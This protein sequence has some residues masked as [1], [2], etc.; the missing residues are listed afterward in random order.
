MFAE[1][2]YIYMAREKFRISQWLR[3]DLSQ[4]HGQLLHAARYW[5]PNGMREKPRLYERGTEKKI[6]TPNQIK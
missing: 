5:F 2:I 1:Y 4:A 6:G 3:A